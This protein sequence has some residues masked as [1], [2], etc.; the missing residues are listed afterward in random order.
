MFGPRKIWQPCS[1]FQAWVKL[2]GLANSSIEI[3]S[4]HWGLQRGSGRGKRVYDAIA[5]GEEED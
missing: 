4:Y 2:F 1:P 3:V 5:E